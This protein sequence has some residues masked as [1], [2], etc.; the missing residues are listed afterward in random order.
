MRCR[1][2][3]RVNMDKLIHAIEHLTHRVADVARIYAEDLEWKKAHDGGLSAADLLALN[4]LVVRGLALAAKASAVAAA[5]KAID[6]ST[7]NSP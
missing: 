7:P 2:L 4:G 1:Y 3:C 5:L 6:D